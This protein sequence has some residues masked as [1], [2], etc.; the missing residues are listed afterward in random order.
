MRRSHE[1]AT[2]G[3]WCA[4]LWPNDEYTAIVAEEWRQD[5]PPGTQG[6][7]ATDTA[8]PGTPATASRTG[9]C[10]PSRRPPSA[11]GSAPR[12]SPRV[13]SW[14]RSRWVGCAECL[15]EYVATLRRSE[16]RKPPMAP[17][18][19]EQDAPRPPRRRNPNLRST[20]YQHND[21][22]WHGRVTV[23]VRDDGRPDRRHVRG[24]TRGEVADE[25]GELIWD[26]PVG[27]SDQ[28]GIVVRR[29]SLAAVEE[30]MA[31]HP[32]RKQPEPRSPDRDHR[33]PRRAVARGGRAGNS[34]R[35]KLRPGG[36]QKD[37]RRLPA[38]HHP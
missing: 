18:P 2:L 14:S 23:G 28:A 31:G 11:F 21:G 35:P 33:P 25:V 1:Q 34:M 26:S 32:R 12:S 36:H 6:W 16:A 22:R 10:L 20:I 9:C 38:Q 37:E 7:V 24:K 27:G 8:P 4:E 19:P 15:P 13:M 29:D 5:R 17:A 3:T 30:C